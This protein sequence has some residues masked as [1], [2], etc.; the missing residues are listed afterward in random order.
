MND[1]SKLAAVKLMQEYILSFEQNFSGLDYNG[2]YV[3][4]F[5]DNLDEIRKLSIDIQR[6]Y[7]SA[8]L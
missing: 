2:E 5:N 1:E 3:T 7:V 6:N 4:R 8:L